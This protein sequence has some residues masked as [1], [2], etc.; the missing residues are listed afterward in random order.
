MIAHQKEPSTTWH[1]AFLAMLP[2]IEQHARVS[3]RSLDPEAHEEAV[4]EVIVTALVAYCRLV[5]LNK[6]DVAFPSTLARYAVAH[7]RVGRQVGCRM[8]SKEVLSSYAQSRRRFSVDRLD[9]YDGE[10]DGWRELVVEDRRAGP[11]EIART[12]LDF[13]DWL[14][15]LT[16]KQ[17]RIANALAVG[18]TTKDV[19]NR[20][21][22]TAGRISQMRHE[23]MD[24]WNAFT[25][26]RP[27]AATA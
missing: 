20:F 18:E 5:E 21:G 4:Q 3:F 22:L 13:S 15:T 27:A 16:T 10:V 7:V 23:L 17:R 1:L 2:A 8:N 14:K 24:C 9:H 25:A 26:D 11:A 19:A 12:R 6:T